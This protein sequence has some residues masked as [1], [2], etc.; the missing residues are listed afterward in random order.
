MGLGIPEMMAIGGGVGLL[1]GGLRGGLTGAALGGLGGAAGNAFKGANF[2]Q[3]AS[4][5]PT[6]SSVAGTI[7]AAPEFLKATVPE[8][9]MANTFNTAQGGLLG[10]TGTPAAYLGSTGEIGANMGLVN[11][12]NA[13]PVA[14]FGSTSPSMLQGAV[15][16]GLT[17][18]SG[19]GELERM[20]AEAAANPGGWEAFKKS[21]PDYVTPQNVLG[22]T[23]ILASMQ[24]PQR[25][26]P[27]MSGGGVRQGQT[28]G[29]NVRMGGAQLIRRR[30]QA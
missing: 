27:S 22:A 14:A 5:V 8:I 6:S 30:G 9:G 20:A 13:A 16:G 1:T 11:A 2:L 17:N 23:S 15:T 28:Q 26:M 7:Q 3:G 4:A 10:A 24:Q 12:M 25:Q 21:L 18:L 19:T 29:L